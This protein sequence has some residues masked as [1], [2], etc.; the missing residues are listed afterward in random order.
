MREFCISWLPLI[1]LENSNDSDTTSYDQWHNKEIRN[2]GKTKDLYGNPCGKKPQVEEKLYYQFE[3]DYKVQ[4]N[5][6]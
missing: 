5:K 1:R 4:W 2:K 6:E 3:R